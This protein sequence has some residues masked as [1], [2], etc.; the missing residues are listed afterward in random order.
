M[1]IL[2][3]ALDRIFVPSA[4]FMCWNLISSVVV[5]EDGAF[6]GWLG[7]E[8]GALMNGISNLIK[9]TPKSSLPPSAV[10]GHSEKTAVCEPGSRLSPDTKSANTLILDFLPSE[11]W[12]INVCC[13][14]HTVYGISVIAAQMD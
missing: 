2:P 8:D 10:W 6:G 4:K 7:Q 12:E 9:A 1:E 14:I 13:L 5:C 3:S 11:M